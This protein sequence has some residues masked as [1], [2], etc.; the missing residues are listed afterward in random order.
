MSI[1]GGLWKGKADTVPEPTAAERCAAL[2]WLASEALRGAA[3]AE[4]LEPGQDAVAV[5]CA[6]LIDSDRTGWAQ[7]RAA[8]QRRDPV[9]PAV[10][11]ALDAEW[12]ETWKHLVEQ[13]RNVQ[14]ANRISRM[15]LYSV[16]LDKL[17]MGVKRKSFKETH[18]DG[19]ETYKPE[20]FEERLRGPADGESVYI[21]A[22]TEKALGWL[23]TAGPDEAGIAATAVV[24]LFSMLD[25]GCPVTITFAPRPEEAGNDAAG[26][27]AAGTGDA[28]DNGDAAGAIA[29][30][31]ALET[32]APAEQSD[33]AS[34][35]RAAIL[36]AIGGLLRC[37]PADVAQTGYAPARDLG[38]KAGKFAIKLAR[39]PA[40][41]PE[42][43]GWVTITKAVRNFLRLSVMV[44]EPNEDEL[45]RA[46][47]ISVMRHRLAVLKRLR[48]AVYLMAGRLEA[49][50]GP[51]AHLPPDEL[52]EAER[53]AEVLD[54]QAA[55]FG[56][57][58]DALMRA[59]MSPAADEMSA[60]RFRLAV[61]ELRAV[62][63]LEQRHVFQA[64]KPRGGADG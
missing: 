10:L 22:L 55:P 29:A 27:D 19:L 18:G 4:L 26:A 49:A 23:Q 47:T 16:N 54:N 21:K 59:A 37:L 62:L 48:R 1:F 38:E 56:E 14:L 3:A 9:R 34:D 20:F 25:I 13:L 17:L 52:L 8:A 64:R 33:A 24:E 44:Y 53:R 40:L 46:D 2:A 41:D 43:E 7:R 57:V 5:G 35:R 11:R 42:A 30:G 60:R 58:T 15:R 61:K 45:R 50:V 39:G 63:T 28:G 12:I 31:L 51:A 32:P 6:R 36:M